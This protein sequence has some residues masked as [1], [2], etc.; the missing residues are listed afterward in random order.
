[1]GLFP[2][3][4][5][6]RPPYAMVLRRSTAVPSPRGW[7]GRNRHNIDCA[8]FLFCSGERRASILATAQLVPVHP[9]RLALVTHPDGQFL[10]PIDGVLSADHVTYD[11]DA[12]EGH[13]YNDVEHAPYIIKIF[14]GG[15]G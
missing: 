1:V 3:Y 10:L 15:R 14:S 4:T 13:D 8:S 12:D 7:P 6:G 11:G 2:W 9:E 5:R